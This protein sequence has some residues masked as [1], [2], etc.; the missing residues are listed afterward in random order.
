MFDISPEKIAVVAAIAFLLLGPDRIPHLAN[1][2]RR[3]RAHLRELTGVIPPEAVQMIRDP[4]RVIMDAF[5]D[6]PTAVEEAFKVHPAP[7]SGAT[8]LPEDASLN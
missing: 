2:L 5:G 3:A 7:P 8:R 6:A 4:R 1:S